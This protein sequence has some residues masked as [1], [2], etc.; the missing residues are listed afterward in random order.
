MLRKER[1]KQTPLNAVGVR[2]PTSHKG[3]RDHISETSATRQRFHYYDCLIL[4][5]NHDRA[6]LFKRFILITV[7]SAEN[8]S[9]HPDVECD[10][11]SFA[12]AGS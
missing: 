6:F 12:I 7:M 10:K 11:K 1:N 5:R 2:E 4:S 3:G 9:D 8:V